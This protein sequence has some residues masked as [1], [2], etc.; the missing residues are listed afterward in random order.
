[1]S[2]R[3]TFNIHEGDTSSDD[4]L[5]FN[6]KI[7]GSHDDD[8]DSYDINLP[9]LTSLSITSPSSL[10]QKPQNDEFLTIVEKQKN[11]SGEI[12]T[13]KPLETPNYVRPYRYK[14]DNFHTVEKKKKGNHQVFYQNKIS[15]S[16]S[17]SSNSEEEKISMKAKNESSS[18]E[19][20]QQKISL[21]GKNQISHSSSSE[22]EDLPYFKEKKQ[23]IP[24]PKKETTTTTTKTT[25]ELNNSPFLKTN[26][27]VS[28]KS[29]LKEGINDQCIYESSNL[30][31]VFQSKKSIESLKETETDKTALLKDQE[32]YYFAY[33]KDESKESLSKLDLNWHCT[34]K[35]ITRPKHHN[36][37]PI[38][39]F[40]PVEDNRQ[41]L[42]ISGM[43]GNADLD[44]KSFTDDVSII[45]AEKIIADKKKMRYWMNIKPLWNKKD[46]HV[47]DYELS[48]SYGGHLRI[49][50][51]L[52][53]INLSQ[54]FDRH[55]HSKIIDLSFSHPE[56]GKRISNLFVF[57]QMEPFKGKGSHTSFI[58]LSDGNVPTMIISF[59]EGSNSL[60]QLWV[61]YGLP[62]QSDIESKVS[63][64]K[65]SNYDKDDTDLDQ[66]Y[67]FF[68]QL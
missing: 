39:K 19:E 65:K 33:L 60:Y 67:S 24:L 55:G 30:E 57:N 68:Q 27:Q 25:I 11:E 61:F 50:D 43:L 8:S 23:Q 35:G 45:I 64:N 59:Y 47:I 63:T 16:S 53:D 34:I 28:L 3:I 40:V 20:Q 21:K 7:Q 13:S 22:S 44:K 5:K 17:S 41:M 62:A 52:S 66:F 6:T 49:Y 29:S 54:F 58:H 2:Q 18:E 38:H 42:L 9:P 14:T 56:T 26:N 48:T 51:L 46:T 1:M 15:M 36:L 31:N 32:D 37:N 10:P 4:E 12:L